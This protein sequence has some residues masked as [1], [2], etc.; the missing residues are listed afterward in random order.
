MTEHSILPPSSAARRMACP[1]SR[2]LEAQIPQQENKYTE[3]GTLAHLLAAS[4]IKE[5]ELSIRDYLIQGRVTHGGFNDEPF[6]EEMIEGAELYRE[7]I[8]GVCNGDFKNVHVEEK[9]DI[10]VVHPECWGT[11]DAWYYEEDPAVNTLYVFDYKF[12]YSYVGVDENWQLISYAA[13][14]LDLLKSQDKT[15]AFIDLIIVQPRGYFRVGPVRHVSIPSDNFMRLL[16]KLQISETLSM[17][18]DAPFKVGGHC[19]NC[20]AKHQCTALQ[21]VTSEIA[22]LNETSKS[23]IANDSDLGKELKVLYQARDI[24][25]ARINGLEAEALSRLQQGARVPYFHIGETQKRDRWIKP[26]KEI[27]EMGKQIYGINLAK[28][29]EL[30]TP[31]Q[32]IK[33]GMPKDIVSTLSERP[34]GEPK[35]MLD[36]MQKIN[37]LLTENL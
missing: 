36:D 2:A 32:A 28:P 17:C 33:A 25:D 14:I 8:G 7:T 11:P 5:F 6:T 10:S 37:K 15:P 3:E 4:A 9:V 34:R 13:G 21:I 27:I 23:I 31:L 19:F 30:I 29:E 20:S 18:D 24:L 12:G 26:A 16:R 22:D 35:L 1:G